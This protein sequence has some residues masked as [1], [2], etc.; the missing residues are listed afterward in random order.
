[1]CPAE[2]RLVFFV[3]MLTGEEEHWW[4]STKSILEEREEVVTWGAFKE[5]FLSEYFP[6]NIR[7]AKEV[8]FLQGLC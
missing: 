8:E 3:Y 5:R 7:Y 2:N 1:M 6:D 4:M